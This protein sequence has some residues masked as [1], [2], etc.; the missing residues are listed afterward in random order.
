MP[1]VVV[2]GRLHPCGIELLRKAPGIELD[3]VEEVSI[4]AL[5]PR[6]PG[7]DAILLRTQ[8]LTAET[9]D[10]CPNLRIVSRHGVGYDAVD[11]ES[12]NR[13]GIPLAIVG[14]VNSRSVAEHA[15]MLMLAA[16]RRLLCYDAATRDGDWDYRNS[17][18]AREMF[19][20]SLLIVGF[21]RIGRCLA[22]I[23]SAFGLRVSA[24]DPYLS[25]PPASGE[26]RMVDDL[27]AALADADFI[28]IHIP[29]TDKPILGPDN[30][31]LLKPTA[32]V[33]NTARGGAADE[34]ALA[35]ALRENRLLGVGI[36]VYSSEPP[37]AGN[38]LTGL[39]RAVL[40]PHSAGMTLESAARMAH[41]AA[42]N[43]IDFF[44]GRL[45]PALVANRD[46]IGIEACRGIGAGARAER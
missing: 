29:G 36:D 1:L 44:N 10:G 45:D 26:V 8:P 39:K 43:I 28:S 21:G 4:E 9:I 33:V 14:D 40:T 2:G 25:G 27:G 46:A 19:S 42:R 13:R 3:Y 24:Y 6:I 23:A 34:Q 37:G 32:V 31:A 11:V 41:S 17:L 12:L 30:I 20:K 38:P 16:G 5:A 15:M 22:Q 18:E 7:A 35:D